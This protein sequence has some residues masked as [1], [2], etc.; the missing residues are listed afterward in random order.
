[1]QKTVRLLMPRQN[2]MALMYPHSLL[3]QEAALLDEPHMPMV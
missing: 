3:F 2:T 1:M